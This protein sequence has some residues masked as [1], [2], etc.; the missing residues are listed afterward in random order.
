MPP[1]FN[2]SKLNSAISKL[3]SEQRRFESKANQAIRDLRR[4]SADLERLGRRFDADNRRLRSQIRRVNSASSTGRFASVRTSTMQLHAAYVVLEQ[5]AISEGWDEQDRHWLA[6]A[7]ADTANS[8]QLANV[9]NG[10]QADEELEE[11]TLTD[12]LTNLSPDLDQRW[13]GA[14]FSLNTRNPD[15]ARQFCT[16]SRELLVE[17]INRWA[18]DDVV[19]RWKPTC[20][21]KDGKVARREKLTY[22]LQT[23]GGHPS[24]QTFAAEDINDVM[25]LFRTFN[26]GTH[27]AA[28]KFDLPA[29]PPLKVRVGVRCGSCPP[30]STLLSPDPAPHTPHLRGQAH[31]ARMSLG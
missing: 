14:L 20:E 29:L 5:T 2:T 1:R 22:L 25:N 26:S 11:T 10:D 23:G 12:E 3:K 28:G 21:M 19:L 27:G 31:S 7:A 18:P 30:S 9:L 6:L 15:A 16:S 17:M 13:Q 24:M 8:A 4:L